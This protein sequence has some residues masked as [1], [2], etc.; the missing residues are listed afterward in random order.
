MAAYP[1][2][3]TGYN[4]DPDIKFQLVER[5]MKD[6]KIYTFE[7]IVGQLKN[8]HGENAEIFY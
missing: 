7:E 3:P 4:S 5:T 2:I 8:E 6:A 1:T